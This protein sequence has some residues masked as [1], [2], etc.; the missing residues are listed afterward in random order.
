MDATGEE[1]DPLLKGEQEQAATA[2][3]RQP[4]NTPIAPGADPA[5]WQVAS[6]DLPDPQVDAAA[7]WSRDG[8]VRGSDGKSL[9]APS[10]GYAVPNQRDAGPILSNL[11]LL[12][13][14]NS[15]AAQALRS[16][17]RN[18]QIVNRKSE[19][20]NQVALANAKAR[21]AQKQIADELAA[22]LAPILKRIEKIAAVAD[23][24]T[25][26]HLLEKLLKDFPALAGAVAADDSVAT[27]LTP[28]LLKSFAEGLKNKEPKS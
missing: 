3:A 11:T 13:L 23:E 2:A 12:G 26:Q 16:Q 5:R 9:P 15:R 20:A 22:S 28:A 10:L 1:V 18:S 21:D 7:G 14:G 4:E 25:Q 6:T 27:A 8:L 17:I 24:A 19:I